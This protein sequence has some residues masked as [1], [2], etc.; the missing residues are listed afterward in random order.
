MLEFAWNNIETILAILGWVVMGPVGAKLGGTI[1]KAGK[2]LK[3]QAGV[4]QDLI[5]DKD[6]PAITKE[7]IQTRITYLA[8]TVTR[9]MKGAK[10][11]K[12]FLDTVAKKLPTVEIRFDKQ[13][14]K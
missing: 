10:S 6:I 3:V 12:T 14:G 9:S 8:S 11:V 2:A 5:E 13:D 7:H 1:G 4:I